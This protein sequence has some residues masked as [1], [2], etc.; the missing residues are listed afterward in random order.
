MIQLGTAALLALLCAVKTRQ[1]WARDR[2]LIALFNL[3][4]IW[5]TICGPATESYTYLILAPAT[6]L[7][8]VQAFAG[9]Q[10]AS[11]RAFAA[12]AFTLQLAAA[13]RASF[14]PHFK[15]L[16]ALTVQPVSGLLLLVY[17]LLW[18]FNNSFWHGDDHI[19]PA[20]STNK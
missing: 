7:S 13:A 14:L 5:M 4:S 6:V 3:V 12:A 8:L 2:T 9:H 17:T 18:L 1:G 15:P 19:P 16:W 20:P 11:L 10:P